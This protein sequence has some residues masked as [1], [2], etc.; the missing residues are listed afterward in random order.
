MSGVLQR[1]Q[2]QS[3]HGGAGATA[4]RCVVLPSEAAL[5][6]GDERSWVAFLSQHRGEATAP[7]DAGGDAVRQAQTV[8]PPVR[9][10]CESHRCGSY[11]YCIV[12]TPLPP[13]TW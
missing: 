3:A 12:A 1:D 11:P 4:A 2:R 8:V 10:E 13:I 9:A 5:Q 7:S 6:R